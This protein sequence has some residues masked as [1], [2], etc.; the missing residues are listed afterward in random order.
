MSWIEGGTASFASSSSSSLSSPSFVDSC[1]GAGRQVAAEGMADVD[2]WVTRP[3]S[4]NAASASALA[5]TIARARSCLNR[6]RAAR[7]RAVI[8]SGAAAGLEPGYNPHGMA[9]VAHG[10]IAHG[11]IG[12]EMSDDIIVMDGRRGTDRDRDQ[13][14]RGHGSGG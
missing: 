9:F 1:S 14:R 2:G 7:R 11:Y 5:A 13:D 3:S 10:Y 8:S 6:R 4:A 12:S